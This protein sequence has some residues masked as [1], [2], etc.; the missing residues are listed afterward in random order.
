MKSGRSRGRNLFMLFFL[1]ALFPRLLVFNIAIHR[2]R[3][4]YK[5]Q[6]SLGYIM[7]AQNLIEGNGFSGGGGWPAFWWPPGYSGFLAVL[8]ATGIAS[9][10]HLAGALLVQVLLASLVA[11]MVSLLALELGGVPAALLAGSLMALEPSSIAHANVILAETFF[12]FLLVLAVLT[13]RG[14]W[15]SPKIHRLLAYAALVGLL[16]LVRPV[17]TYLWVPLALLLVVTRPRAVPR[18]P[19]LVGFV[20]LATFPVAA[21]TLRNYSYLHVPIFATVGQFNEARFAHNVEELAGEPQASSTVKQPWQDGFGPDQGMSFPQLVKAREEYFRRVL[22]KHPVAA[23]ER[24]ALGGA[25]ILGVPDS[26]LPDLILREVPDFQGG[27]VRGRL[28]WLWRLGWLGGLLLLGMA[29]STG[30]FLALP[31]LALR[32]RVWP[33]DKQAFLALMVLLI[34]YQLLISSFIMYQADRFRVPI[35]PLLA[36]A[37]GSALRGDRFGR[38]FNS[39]SA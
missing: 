30:G 29:V 20:A 10:E 21:W 3:P 11:G 17:A 23:L 9:P 32:A 5:Y 14:W 2:E 39:D 28:T 26:R 38:R 1:L 4:V 25:G 12:T 33:R 15:A 37:L 35:V 7:P 27:S 19:V 16:P 34:L 22:L 8:F 6:D 31:L 13:W 18:A 36:V 24:L